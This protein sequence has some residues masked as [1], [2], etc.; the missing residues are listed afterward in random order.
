MAAYIVA[1]ASLC[2]LKSTNN[3]I[4]WTQYAPKIAKL[5]RKEAQVCQATKP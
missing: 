3:D 2:S 5:K 1:S 4:K